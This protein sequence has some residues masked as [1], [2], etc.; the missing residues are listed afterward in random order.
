MELCRK[1]ER[2]PQPHTG[3][4][5]AWKL[6]IRHRILRPFQIG[7]PENGSGPSERQQRQE[8]LLHAAAAA[9]NNRAF[10][11]VQQRQKR[12]LAHIPDVLH[13]RPGHRDISESV[14][15]SGTGARLCICGI[16]LLLFALDRPRSGCR[17]F[18]YRRKGFRAKS[19][20]PRHHRLRPFPWHTASY[21]H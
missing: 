5:T 4:S 16:I 15:L 11:S 21:G 12:L 2:Y 3:R 18:L 13:D 10:L 6:G 8:P 19:R 14:A 20:N 9:W 17:P 1:T 7:R